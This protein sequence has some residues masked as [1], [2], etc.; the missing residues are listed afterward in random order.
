VTRLNISSVFGM[1]DSKLDSLRKTKQGNGFLDKYFKILDSVILTYNNKRKEEGIDISLVHRAEYLARRASSP[2]SAIFI[3]DLDNFTKLRLNRYVDFDESDLCILATPVAN[4][5]ESQQINIS[6]KFNEFFIIK[7]SFTSSAKPNDDKSTIGLKADININCPQPCKPGGSSISIGYQTLSNK[8]RLG[9]LDSLM[10]HSY[11]IQAGQIRD[12]TLNNEDYK[13]FTFRTPFENGEDWI[14]CGLVKANE[15]TAAT[16]QLSPYF[17]VMSTLL[18]LFLFLS[19]PI[20]KL[21]VM[22]ETERLQVSNVWFIGFSLFTGTVI[23]TLLILLWT[24]RQGGKKGLDQKITNLSDEIELRFVSELSSV[25]EQ[26]KQF[27][28]LQ[29]TIFSHQENDSRKRK[30]LNGYRQVDSA[31]QP[32]KKIDPNFERLLLDTLKFPWFNE[33]IW[34]DKMGR[35]VLYLSTHE[36]D[37]YQTP[38][39]L[40]NRE[41]FKR[42]RDNDLWMLGFDAGKRFGFQSIHS[43]QNGDSEA[44][45]SIPIS[46]D[47][48]LA[49]WKPKVLAIAT[50]LY[51]VMDPLLPPGYSFCIIDDSG[52]VQF[53]SNSR[54]NLQENLFDEASPKEALRAAVKG[55]QS[56]TMEFDYGGSSMQALINPIQTLPLTIVVMTNLEYYDAPITL[57]IGYAGV[58]VTLM[59]AL[60]GLTLF[61]L[62][63]CNY[64]A[65]LLKVKHFSLAWLSPSG[66][67]GQ[68]KVSLIFLTTVSIILMFLVYISS[69]LW[70]SIGF[71]LLPG[72]LIVFHFLL[73]RKKEIKENKEWLFL[74]GRGKVPVHPYLICSLAFALLIN[75]F[76]WMLLQ[77][78]EIYKLLA[79][80]IG[81]IG[82]IVFFWTRQNSL[83]KIELKSSN[84][85]KIR[86]LIGKL[87]RYPLVYRC[88]CMQ[89]LLVVAVLGPIYFY[90]NGYYTQ[91]KI[92]QRS[93]LVE[94]ARAYTDRVKRFDATRVFHEALISPD[95]GALENLGNYVRQTCI[96]FDT[97]SGVFPTRPK[98]WTLTNEEQLRFEKIIFSISPV[99][100]STL[101]LARQAIISPP[102]NAIWIYGGNSDADSLYYT[103]PTPITIKAAVPIDTFEFF[104]GEY[105][106]LILCLSICLALLVWRAICFIIKNIF[107]LGFFPKKNPEPF[108]PSDLNKHNKIFLVGLPGSG[109]KESVI[110][111]LHHASLVDFR[112]QPFTYSHSD[113]VIIWHF[114]FGMNDHELNKLKFDFL[115]RLIATGIKKVIILSAAQPTAILDFYDKMIKNSSPEH[116]RKLYLEYK[117]SLRYWK[118]LLVNFA[119]KYQPLTTGTVRTGSFYDQEF[120][121]GTFLKT[122]KPSLLKTL[123]LRAQE[124][125]VIQ[126]SEI[127]EN[128]YQSLWNSLSNTEKNI[129][130]DLAKDG[131]VNFK[132]LN[133]IKILAQKGMLTLHPTVRIMNRSF[134]EFILHVVKEDEEMRME[135]EARKSGTW[136]TVQLALIITLFGLA[137]FI[138]LAKE[139]FLGNFNAWIT[140]ITGLFALITRFGGSF[141]SSKIK[142]V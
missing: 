77:P 84:A 41:Y 71:L 24:H 132:N 125:L 93:Q 73:F 78:F 61:L 16:R 88:L 28:S 43:W 67:S 91:N 141:G 111:I 37:P 80:Q 36:I 68:Y 58:M 128:Y 86:L 129:L 74:L 23:I 137:S 121:H 102:K 110:N 60:I 14:L 127:S 42:A 114:E 40:D 105:W 90:K 48:T 64:Q 115:N 82:L 109:K 44:G 53:H 97:V 63:L 26:L 126:T 52:E 6:N 5:F 138:A 107:G 2:D 101:E 66:K 76:G 9:S 22:S 7:E 75:A 46:Y 69:G 13:L 104:N 118:N 85:G 56:V 116:D 10:S 21:L 8:I 4:F 27:Q 79:F 117:Q 130:F 47:S 32:P 124:E 94:S 49:P 18:V 112:I 123:S 25:V 103:T 51:S 72:Y 70:L 99:F 119:V 39:P 140:A 142:E 122:L 135:Q 34:M 96:E 65:S 139:G 95:R 33:A 31:V 108:I 38:I 131:F 30:V 3:I 113:A 1:A 92:W 120:D 98:T 100:N 81:L 50:R 87:L 19:M 89:W 83:S 59:I 17:F 136:A 134:T 54:L 57:A 62:F 106:L 35:Q 133:A 20:L 55:R 15:F 12:V 11:G 29:G 45:I